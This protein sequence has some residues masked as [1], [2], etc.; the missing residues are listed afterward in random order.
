MYLLCTCLWPVPLVS[1]PSLGELGQ[2]N[3][4]AIAA[5]VMA[6]FLFGG[7]SDIVI[8]EC[9]VDRMAAGQEG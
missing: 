3:V 9:T 1:A 8:A 7:W 2:L 5:N 4:V 6:P